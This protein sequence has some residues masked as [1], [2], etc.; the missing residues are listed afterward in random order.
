MGDSNQTIN[1][2]YQY[3]SVEELTKLFNDVKYIRLNSTYRS[4]AEIID[5]SNKILGLKEV[6]SIRPEMN[7]PVLEKEENELK[8]DLLEDIEYFK[9]K[10]LKRI[11][12]ITKTDD[13][14]QN[15]FKLLG[16]KN[17]SLVTSSILKDIVI[18]PSYLA[19]GL[20]F[21]GVIAYSSKDDKYTEE[22]KYL[23]YVVTTRAQHALIVYNQK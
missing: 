9:S 12:V 22:E 6:K 21:D 10:G 15:I 4:S 16:S 18:V 13:E 14:S 11:A 5:Y 2:Y 20:E 7:M 1:P 23:F 17:V 8:K 3:T 19:K